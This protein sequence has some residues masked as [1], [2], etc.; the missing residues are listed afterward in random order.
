MRRWP[1]RSMSTACLTASWWLW[2]GER[3]DFDALQQ[4]VVNTAVTVRTRLASAQRASFIVFDVLAVDSVDIRTMRWTAR[5]SRLE[6]LAANWQPPLQLS[7]VT[8]DPTEAWEWLVAFKASGVE[9]LV[10]KGASTRYHPGRRDWIK[11]NSVG[12][13]V[14]RSAPSPGSGLV[15][16]H[17]RQGTA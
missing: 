16:A 6:S 2:T 3:L 15:T 17:P 5:R 7:P 9:G 11:A 10:V 14:V 8:D 4:R 1:R 12:V 13:G